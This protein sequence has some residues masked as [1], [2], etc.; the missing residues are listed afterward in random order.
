MIAVIFEAR[1]MPDQQGRYLALAAELKAQLSQI[2][3]FI[4]I[5]RFQSLSTEGKVL[6]LSW[7]ES[8]EAVSGWRNSYGNTLLIQGNALMY[9]IHVILK[10]TPGALAQLGLT[11][12]QNG[13]GLEGGGV[14]TVD[15]T[16]HAHFLVEEGERARQVLS[17]AGM[18]V[19]RISK[20]LIRRLRQERPGELGEIARALAAHQI[21]IHVQYSDHSNRLIL[22]TDNDQLAAEVTEKWSTGL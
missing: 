2:A 10:H 14:F 13:V 4:E 17:A 1:A 3:G 20:P 6:S 18:H 9:D 19:E 22:L 11:L 12:G 21:T 15:E 8:E 16:S 5:E 7:W